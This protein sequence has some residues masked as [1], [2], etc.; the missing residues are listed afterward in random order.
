MKEWFKLHW[1]LFSYIFGK[2]FFLAF[3]VCPH[4]NE[5]EEKYCVLSIFL[6]LPMPPE[7]TPQEWEGCGG[8]MCSELLK[9]KQCLCLSNNASN[10][11]NTPHWNC[12]WK[13][14]CLFWVNLLLC[15]GPEQGLCTNL[16]CAC[17]SVNVLLYLFKKKKK[18]IHIYDVSF[19]LLSLMELHLQRQTAFP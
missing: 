9:L 6:M 18:Q 10:N 13:C 5:P 3:R 11:L 8:V 14:I 1:F 7:P 2:D 16:S 17:S 19:Y 4:F 12:L 15:R